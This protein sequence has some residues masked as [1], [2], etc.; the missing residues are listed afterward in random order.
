MTVPEDVGLN[1]TLQLETVA[2][3]AARVQ[4]EPV[5]DPDAVPPFVKATVP[6]GADA[7]PAAEVSRTNPV[8]VVA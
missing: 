1:V 4:G 8:Q 5:N 2:L 7:V 3:T 6:R